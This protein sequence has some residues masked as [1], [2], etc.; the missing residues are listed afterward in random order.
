MFVYPLLF[1]THTHTHTHTHLYIYRLVV[2]SFQKVFISFK[3]NILGA[4][5]DY[6][7]LGF[8]MTFVHVHLQYIIPLK[9]IGIKK[10]NKYSN[11]K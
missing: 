7:Y 3:Q 10:T 2:K 9:I 11:I 4:W 6:F 8:N 5:K 1:V